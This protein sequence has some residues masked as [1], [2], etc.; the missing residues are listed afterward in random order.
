PHLGRLFTPEDDIPDALPV[1]I[2]SH[3][4]WIRHFG[5]D[6][7]IVGK[8][9]ELDSVVREV[10]G[11]MPQGF[12]FLNPATEYWTAYGLD[13][14][15]DWHTSAAR[16]IPSILGRLKPGVTI[17]AAQAEMRTIARQLEQSYAANKNNSVS[18]VALRDVLTDE[19]RWSL[20]VLLAAVSGLL[21]VACFNV[22]G[23]MF[24]RSASRQREI[25]VRV[26]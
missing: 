17:A 12:Y 5:G 2:L 1:V 10:I 26:S 24:A 11:V 25:A 15:R 7:A 18:V 22:A 8:K 13:R 14:N 23:M 9:I 21:F 6:P 4:L 19:V 20:I 3:N 16:T